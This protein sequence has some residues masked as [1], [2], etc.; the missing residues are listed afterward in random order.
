MA[1]IQ[2]HLLKSREKIQGLDQL[3]ITVEGPNSAMG[4]C[5]EKLPSYLLFT[6]LLLFVVGGV[7]AFSALIREGN[8]NQNKEYG[9]R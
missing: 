2:L 6:S 5:K 4:R 3:A 1:N 7:I 9:D 8:E